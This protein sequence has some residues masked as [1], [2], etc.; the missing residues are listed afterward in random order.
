MA[1]NTVQTYLDLITSAHAQQP[2]FVATVS[3]SVG[4]YV[5]IQ[6]LFTSMI[7]LFDLDSPPVGNQLDII[8]QWAGVSRNVLIP[9]DEVFFTWDGTN[10]NLGWDQGTWAPEG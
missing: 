6:N 7:S 3:L 1:Q 9:G 4:A 10:A 2:N 8:G 5:Q